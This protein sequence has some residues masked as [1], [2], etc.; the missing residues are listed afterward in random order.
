MIKNKIVKKGFTLIELL[1]VISIIGILAGLAVVSFTSS[2]KQAR[3]TSR[4]SDLSQYRTLL[5]SY[6]NKNESLYPAYTSAVTASDSLCTVLNTSLGLT[7]SCPEDP[8][9]E[10]VGVYHYQSNGS[11]T[12]GTAGA[13]QY[14]LWAALENTPST[15]WVVCSTGESGKTTSTNFSAG[16]CPSTLEK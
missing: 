6:A 13:T 12:S 16:S 3:D 9:S 10:S 11:G 5:E 14:V 8:K 4:K 1:V 7:S 2:Q 15:F